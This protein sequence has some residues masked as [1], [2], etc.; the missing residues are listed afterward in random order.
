MLDSYSAGFPIIV[1]AILESIGIAWIYGAKR[2]TND[3]RTMIGD[4]YVDFP[5]FKIWPLLW[6]CITPAV[7]MVRE[8]C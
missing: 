4:G 8:L 1:F 2:F 7:L 3:I 6:G 5:L